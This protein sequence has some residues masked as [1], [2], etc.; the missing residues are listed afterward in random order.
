[1]DPEKYYIFIK[2]KNIHQENT[3]ILNIYAPNTRAPKF[4][5]KKTNKQT[6]KT[7]K[8]HITA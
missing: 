2:E 1:M 8:P 5:K 6:K 3:V 4:V 7:K